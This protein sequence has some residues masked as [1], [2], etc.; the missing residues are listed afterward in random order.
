MQL[1]SKHI[2]IG[3]NIIVFGL[4]TFI[5]LIPFN[6]QQV[7]QDEYAIKYN[8]FTN[9]F[10]DSVLTQG[11]YFM[12][13]SFEFY[14]FKRTLQNIELNELNC[15]TRD[16][17]ILKL[18]VML[19]IQYYPNTLKDTLLKQFLN[20]QNY[21]ELINSIAYSTILNSC[22]Y[23]SVEQYYMERSQIDTMMYDQL[24]SNINMLNVK[25][26]VIFFQLVN[27]KFPESYSNLIKEKQNIEQNKQTAL[28]DRTNKIT[29]AQTEIIIS[30][31]N[32]MINL[33][34]A[35][36]S[37]NIILNKANLDSKQIII[38]WNLRTNYLK[39]VSN[40]LE[41]NPIDLL[42]YFK[43]EKISTTQNIIVNI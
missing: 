19:Q 12:P 22:L 27:I 36:M 1:T 14:K 11:I 35:N 9:N 37:S 38:F 16:K 25:S 5:F 7:E 4:L 21:K 6:I 13:F 26:K 40:E 39:H 24:F 20:D 18:H 33:I 30:K 8:I 15:M 10:D 32:A 29:Q 31:K 3:I 43:Q 23:W 28:N 41:L 2:F 34:N 42:N 17:V